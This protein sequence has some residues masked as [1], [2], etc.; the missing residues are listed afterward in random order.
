MKSAPRTVTVLAA[1]VLALLLAASSG[2][3]AAKMITGK[4]IKNNTVTSADIKNKSLK[5]KDLHPG[6]VSAL[7]GEAGPAG[8]EGPAG[9]VGPAGPATLPDTY[10]VFEGTDVIPAG[11]DGFIGAA[12]CDQGD[13]VISGFAFWDNANDALQVSIGYDAELGQAGVVAYSPGVLIDDTAGIQLLCA[14]GSSA[15]AFGSGASLPQK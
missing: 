1:L 15:P 6:T 13:S 9:P 14:V 2:A 7:E 4:Q 11:T 10:N 5:L 3:V 12:L 8:A